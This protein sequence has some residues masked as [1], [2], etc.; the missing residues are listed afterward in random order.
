[1]VHRYGKDIICISFALVSTARS[2]HPK[3]QQKP[4]Q[5]KAQDVAPLHLTGSAGHFELERYIACCPNPPVWWFGWFN[6]SQIWF[7]SDFIGL[8]VALVRCWS[9]FGVVGYI[10]ICGKIHL[11]ILVTSPKFVG[12]SHP[13]LVLVRLHPELSRLPPRLLLRRP[14]SQLRLRRLSPTPPP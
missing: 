14:R 1:M 6:S 11:R 9:N 7:I 12:R 2:L 4:R 3:L 13:I 8:V 10:W 5:W